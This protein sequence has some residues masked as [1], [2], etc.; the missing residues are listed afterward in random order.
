MGVQC[1]NALVQVSIHTHLVQNWKR[2]W[3]VLYRNELKY[4]NSKDD[5][6]PIKTINLEDVTSVSRDDSTG[7]SHCFRYNDIVV[8]VHF[9]VRFPTECF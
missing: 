3:F 4:F 8:H 5:K 9:I 6:E 2:R 7:K 1:M